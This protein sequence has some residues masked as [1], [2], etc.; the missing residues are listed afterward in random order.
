M[1]LTDRELAGYVES[2]SRAT[3][4]CDGK[5]FKEHLAETIPIP[6]LVS[7]ASSPSMRAE[8]L[9]AVANSVDKAARE[10]LLQ[11]L[12]I[13]LSATVKWSRRRIKSSSSNRITT[14]AFPLLSLLSPRKPRTFNTSPAAGRPCFRIRFEKSHRIQMLVGAS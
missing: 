3:R 8:A 10:E 12:P 6:P 2:G 14:W 5:T 11:W 4:V 1:R 7:R 9:A 13:S